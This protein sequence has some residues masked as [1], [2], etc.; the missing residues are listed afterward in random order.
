ME[1]T[2]ETTPPCDA[3]TPCPATGGAVPSPL[4]SLDAQAIRE[5]SLVQLVQARD[6]A[7]Y[8][9]LSDASWAGALVKLADAVDR[10][11]GGAS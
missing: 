5:E 11:L 1:M 6:V 3:P 4:P 7:A 2:F 10:R 9:A 8:A